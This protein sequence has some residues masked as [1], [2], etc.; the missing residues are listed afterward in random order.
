MFI[1]RLCGHAVTAHGVAAWASC[2]DCRRTIT[3]CAPRVRPIT[4]AV[5]V[6]DA[7][8]S[9]TCEEYE[10]S[11]AVLRYSQHGKSGGWEDGSSMRC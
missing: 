11:A 3:T 2:W 8:K 5:S 4:W 6:R 1:L 9:E 7:D 10:H